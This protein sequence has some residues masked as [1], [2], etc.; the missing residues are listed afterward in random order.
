MR[1]PIGFRFAVSVVATATAF[2]VLAQD[3]PGPLPVSVT[4]Q[5]AATPTVQPAAGTQAP[6]TAPIQRF[7]DFRNLPPET[8]QAI[9]AMRAGADWLWR[10]N[11]PNGR[12]L[13]GLNPALKSALPDDP[14][15]RQAV[16]TLALCRAARFTA[17]ERF[18]ARA[19]QAVLAQLS[20]TKPDPANPGIRVPVAPS[21]RCNR[22]GFAAVLALAIYDMPGADPKLLADAD[23]LVNF[24]RSKC[25]ADGPVQA[26]DGPTDPAKSDPDTM[27]VYPGLGLQAMAVANRRRPDAALTGQIA[28][29]VNYYRAAFKTQ[30]HP[31]LAA[32]VLPAITD[33][34]LT[35]KDGSV[36][37]V[38][39][40][41]ADGLCGFQY[42]RSETPQATWVGGFR[43]GANAEPRWESAVYAEALAS[44]ATLTRNVPDVGR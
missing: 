41:L 27:N 22:V 14:D 43:A 20:L 36:A 12:F 28:R 24:L 15:F 13:S 30:P 39:F 5:P 42:T 25:A 44:A 8:V 40:E 29:G 3:P 1:P 18:C 21:E 26:F 31:M 38:G 2:A 16:A 4:G 9:Y 19:A 11:Q 37:A 34:Y 23:A 17:D 32:S 33:L 6:P 35:T 10:M 7:Q